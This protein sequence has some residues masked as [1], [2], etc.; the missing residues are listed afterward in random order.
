M[1]RIWFLFMGRTLFV[2]CGSCSRDPFLYENTH[3]LIFVSV[4][5]IIKPKKRNSANLRDKM[6]FRFVISVYGGIYEKG[7][8]F[9]DGNLGSFDPDV[10]LCLRRT[11]EGVADLRPESGY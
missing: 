11:N 8:C 9:L 2:K 4:Y 5:D 1:G 6:L 3:H 7:M 10:S